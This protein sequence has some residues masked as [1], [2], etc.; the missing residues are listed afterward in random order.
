MP[1]SASCINHRFTVHF[2]PSL[3]PS[4]CD[5][6]TPVTPKQNSTVITPHPS[7]I[8]MQPHPSINNNISSTSVA[9]L[10]RHIDQWH[11]SAS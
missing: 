1:E 10:V 9:P 3:P 6:P 2:F 11:T 5:F 7:P 4:R 8:Q